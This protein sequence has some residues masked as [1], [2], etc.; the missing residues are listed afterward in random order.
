MVYIKIKNEKQD[1][2]RYEC[3]YNENLI[4]RNKIA[5]YISVSKQIF[6]RNSI[7]Y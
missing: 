2:I 4:N 1:N 7:K 5:L 6:K 3:W